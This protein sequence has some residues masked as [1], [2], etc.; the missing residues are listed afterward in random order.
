MSCLHSGIDLSERSLKV[1]MVY[2][3]KNIRG[4]PLVFVKGEG[5]VGQ[6]SNSECSYGKIFIPRSYRDLGFCY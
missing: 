5:H 4:G 2:L 3:P 1:Y 6:F